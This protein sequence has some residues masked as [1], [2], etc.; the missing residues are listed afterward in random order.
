MDGS[1]PRTD[2][3]KA[4]VYTAKFKIEGYIHLLLR[5]S[6]RGRLSD[7]LNNG[8]ATHFIPITDASIYDVN[9]GKLVR[10]ANCI[11]VN[12]RQVESLIE[13]EESES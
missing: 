5:D 4:T 10:K 3:I 9:S 12:K 13:E 6:Y 8:P 7:H 2:M 1:I 11:I